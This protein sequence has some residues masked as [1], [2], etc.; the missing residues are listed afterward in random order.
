MD[1]VTGWAIL[2]TLAIVCD[3]FLKRIFG[4]WEDKE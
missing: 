2:C 3:Y 1:L 4:D